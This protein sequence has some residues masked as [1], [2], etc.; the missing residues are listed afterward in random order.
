MDFFDLNLEYLGSYDIQSKLLTSF[1][2]GT[3]KFT[4]WIKVI[5]PLTR[6]NFMTDYPNTEEGKMA[7]ETDLKR[8]LEFS[9]MIRLG[10]ITG[11]IDVTINNYAY[12]MLSYLSL[13]F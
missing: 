7:F 9:E 8:M 13:N 6:K 1:S 4:D 3:T 2:S 12:S 5:S 10:L 11:S